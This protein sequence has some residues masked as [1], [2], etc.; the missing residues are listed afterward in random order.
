MK[1]GRVIPLR[2]AKPM[3]LD[4]RIKD[5]PIDFSARLSPLEKRWCIEIGERAAR[6][7]KAEGA[8]VPGTA[9]ALAFVELNPAIA[10]MD[11]AVAHVHRDFDLIAFMRAD[12]LTLM[13]EFA[14]IQRHINRPLCIFPKDVK[15]RFARK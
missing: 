10:V 14:I 5:S 8:P 4:P 7:H 12:D 2:D 9:D 6:M 11:I 15:L 13:A 1:N 3:H